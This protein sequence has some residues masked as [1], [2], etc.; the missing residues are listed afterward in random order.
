M[1]G[2]DPAGTAGGSRRLAVNWTSGALWQ[3]PC[4]QLRPGRERVTKLTTVRNISSRQ[5][6]VPAEVVSFSKSGVSEEA[7]L[8]D[9]L[10]DI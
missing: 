9:F 1:H 5:Q 3:L 8:Q 2:L 10:L 7:S 6:Q 4:R